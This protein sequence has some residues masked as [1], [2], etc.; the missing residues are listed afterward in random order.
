M[1]LSVHQKLDGM[2]APLHVLI[3]KRLEVSEDRAQDIV[4]TLLK[5]LRERAADE[6][7]HLPQL[8]TF[9]EEQGTLTFSPSPSLRRL[10]NQQYEGLQ[11]ETTSVSPGTDEPE[12]EA[13]HVTAPADTDEPEE[14]PPGEEFASPES[15]PDEEEPDQEKLDT[16]RIEEDDDSD[17]EAAPASEEEASV[18]SPADSAPTPD[19]SV[20]EDSREE[21]PKRR[22]TASSIDSFQFVIGILLFVFLIA[23]GWFV[24]RQTHVIPAWPGLSLEQA[25]PSAGPDTAMATT[26]NQRAAE[27]DTASTT[28]QQMRFP[29][30][31]PGEGSSRDAITPAEG[32]WT[33]VVASRS[34]RGVAETQLSQ[35]ESR[36]AET[37]LPVDIVSGSVGNSTRYRVAI[38]QY[39]S[40]DAAREALNE[41]A[42]KLPDGAWILRL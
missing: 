4:R 10:V 6:S 32:G 16:S 22:A 8:G 17:V 35:Y 18:W 23:A 14:R 3:A 42:S 41:H 25:A 36:F 12:E 38:G 26:E 33:I 29:G 31:T 37:G 19:E 34:N 2:S 11:P 7:V 39:R 15:E 21:E 40:R 20:E 13:A 5:E 30:T 24:L 9:R 1:R 27:D 28:A